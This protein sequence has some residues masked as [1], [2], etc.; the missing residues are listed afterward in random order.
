MHALPVHLQRYIVE[1]NYA[2][3]SPLDQAVWRF[4]LRQLRAF[5]TLH[6]HQGYLEGLAKTGIDVETIPK[7]SDISAKLE[8]FGW[9][10]LPV[11][12]FI[13]PAA[14]MELQ[15]LSVLPIA[16]D[17][18]TLE[19]LLYTPAP[20]IVHEAAGHAPFIA[21]PEYAD[22][23]RKYAQVARKAILSKE[24]LDLYEAIRVLSDLKENPESTAEEINAAQ[25]RLDHLSKSS[26]HVSEATELGRMNW[27]TA[28]YGLIGD[29]KNP[30]LFGAG[31]LSSVGESKLCLSE[32]VKKIPLTVDCIKQSYDITEPQPQLF[33][34][35]NF[36]HLGEV[37]EQMAAAMAFRVGG[38]AGLKKAQRAATVNTAEWSSGLQA[39]GVLAEISEDRGEPTYL[40]FEGPCQLSCDEKQLA[41]HSQSYHAQGFSSPVGFL[42][43]FDQDPANLQAKD[44]SG[45]GL[46]ENERAVLMFESGVKVDGVFKKA[47]FHDGRLLLLT[48]EQCKVTQK[49]RVFFEPAWG[50]YDMAVGAKIKSVFGGAADRG[51]YGETDDFVAARVPERKYSENEKNLHSQYRKIRELRESGTRAE[52]MSRSLATLVQE[53]DARFPS[54]WLF[55]VEA[56]ELILNRGPAPELEKRVR[57]N[58]ERIKKTKPEAR[59]IIDD[60][61]SQAGKI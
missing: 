50:T 30:R 22:Y 56:L 35:P 12:G 14:F 19:H 45:L 28:E 10:A 2:K 59:E 20:D 3:Y 25:D 37:L 36:H 39:S 4:I 9:R 47:L 58:L 53:H 51:A 38:L 33:V 44:L 16:S 32:K 34:T 48:F 17:L 6:A 23:L 26:T 46:R 60:G 29:L 13:P 5:L 27:W 7:I 18:R 24:D 55:Q 40:R 11:S 41:G 1:Q 52:E 54:D 61:I 49:D 57:E 21:D 43:D 8:K 31:L 42:R 15:S